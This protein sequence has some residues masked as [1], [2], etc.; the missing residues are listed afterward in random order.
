MNVFAL[1]E[2][3]VEQKVWDAQNYLV[4]NVNQAPVFYNFET[5]WHSNTYLIKEKFTTNWFLFTPKKNCSSVYFNVR[6]CGECS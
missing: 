2:K 3:P 6:L 4:G 5:G 1:S